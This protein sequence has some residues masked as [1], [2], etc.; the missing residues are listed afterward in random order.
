MSLSLR[1]WTPPCALTCC[2]YA[3]DARG[4]VPQAAAG[5]ESGPVRPMVISVSV[6]PGTGGAARA[7]VTPRKKDTSAAPIKRISISEPLAGGRG[8]NLL[9]EPGRDGRSTLQELG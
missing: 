7:E 2:A 6:T 3:S 1:P 4:I 8:V 9:H 5:P